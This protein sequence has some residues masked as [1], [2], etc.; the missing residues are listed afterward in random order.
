MSLKGIIRLEG[1]LICRTGLHIGALVKTYVVGR[2]D[3]P[4]FRGA[5]NQLC[6]PGSA[7]R[8]KLRFLLEK[9]LQQR[10][11]N[12]GEFFKK[13]VVEGDLSTPSNPIHIHTCQD[14]DCKLCRLFG[15]TPLT[16]EELQ[17]PSPLHIDPLYLSDDVAATVEPEVKVENTLDRQ[18]LSAN[19]RSMERVGRGTS[20]PLRMTY[21]IH[22]YSHLAEDLE[23]LAASFRLLADDA[24]GGGG[25]R[26]SGAIS[27][28]IT[29]TTVRAFSQS[30]ERWHD[31]KCSGPTVLEDLIKEVPLLV[32]RLQTLNEAAVAHKVF[33]QKQ[34]SLKTWLVRMKF[35]TP[36]HIGEPGIGLESSLSYVPSDTLFSALCHAAQAA[37]GNVF[38]EALLG[39]FLAA[40]A[41]SVPP[42][43]V[44][45]S[46]FPF[47]DGQYYLPKPQFP[48]RPQ[49][50]LLLPSKMEQQEEEKQ[51]LKALDF[52]PLDLFRQWAQEGLTDDSNEAI[53][54]AIQNLKTQPLWEETVVARARIDRANHRSNLYFCSQIE[55]PSAGGLFV[56]ITGREEIEQP[57]RICFAMLGELGLGGERTSGFGKFDVAEQDWLDV[58]ACEE[59]QDLITPQSTRGTPIGY[60]SLSL[61]SPT[62]Q[63]MELLQTGV[64]IPRGYAWTLRGGWVTLT[65][66]GI[67]RRRLAC[68]L[69]TEGTTLLR[70]TDEVTPPIGRLIEV[71]GMGGNHAI[72]RSGLAF[73]VPVHRADLAKRSE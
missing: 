15:N 71:G 58:T 47:Q 70:A 17:I 27:I 50:D 67:P 4:F 61:Y 57:L 45:S 25:S 42:P 10:S 1:T 5:Q 16:K 49:S 60:C 52:I 64:L 37:Y 36:L 6:I 72:Y 20:F 46:A 41:N 56:L 63:E 14:R 53:E 29:R 2:T 23:N 54:R 18:T 39:D 3:T 28:Q 11:H 44:L 51:T 33:L 34:T 32:R 31:R 30:D 13:L 9:L 35:R 24:L 66:Q 19:P 12:P 59:V 69:L 26:G 8:G 65:D 43:F 48:S 73:C 21:F 68:R 55:F 22:D 7:L 40:E 38:I 62:E